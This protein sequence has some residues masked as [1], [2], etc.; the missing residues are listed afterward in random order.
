MIQSFGLL[1]RLKYRYKDRNNEKGNLLLCA[2]GN[3]IFKDPVARR[4][5]ESKKKGG[6]A[7]F[8]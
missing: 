1:V 5:M 7:R 4:S 2:F 8:R 6:K 3:N